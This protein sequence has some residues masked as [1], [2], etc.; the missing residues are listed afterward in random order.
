MTIFVI[1]EFWP[2]NNGVG[3]FSEQCVGKASYVKTRSMR[4]WEIRIMQDIEDSCALILLKKRFAKN[5][6]K[7]EGLLAYGTTHMNISLTF[8]PVMLMAQSMFL[9]I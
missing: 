1:C 6:V 5:D 7:A 3:K 4:M 9:A 2:R 8:T